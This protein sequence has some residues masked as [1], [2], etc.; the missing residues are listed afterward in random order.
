MAQTVD[1]VAPYLNFCEF[2]AVAG[3]FVIWHRLRVHDRISPCPREPI[4]AWNSS[5]DFPDSKAVSMM[6]KLVRSIW[7]GTISVAGLSDET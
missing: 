4:T 5:C 3:D 6:R 1:D 2:P 7:A